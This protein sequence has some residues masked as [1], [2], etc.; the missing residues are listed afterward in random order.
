MKIIQMISTLGGG[1]AEAIV[2]DLSIELK[3]RGHEVKVLVTTKPPINGTII[4]RQLV[5]EGI[6]IDWLNKK[7]G[8]RL[9]AFWKVA[10]YLKS[11]QP[12]LVHVHLSSL[13]YLAPVAIFKK[14]PVVYTVH[15]ISTAAEIAVVRALYRVFFSYFPVTPVALSPKM[16]KMATHGYRIT[17]DKVQCISNGIVL[18]KYIAKT[19]WN[20]QQGKIV[21]VHVGRFTEV[22]NH[23]ALLDVFNEVHA[24]YPNS[25]LQFLGDGPLTEEIKEKTAKLGLQD[26]IKF[27]G[28]QSNVAPYLNNAD[29]FLL[30]SL[31]EAMP[32]ALA[33]AM[34]TALPVIA[35]PV[36]GIP[37]M[38]EN[39]KNG[40]VCEVSEFAQNII[41]LI[42]HP[43]LRESLGKQAALTA[44]NFSVQ[45]MTGQYLELYQNLK[46]T[47]N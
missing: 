40:I 37:D 1:G 7:K 20:F 46:K 22:K 5:N 44:Q 43:E 16:Q 45:N 39:G 12:D 32:L 25:E 4:S 27:L 11:E 38:I 31:A 2:R 17:E 29:F 24:Q 8:F 34:A 6:Q 15:Y 18:Q 19:N 10:A 3:K 9:S 41:L 33:E 42:E 26:A 28:L 47:G 14:I 23:T 35:T 30:P 13:K 21:F 36:G